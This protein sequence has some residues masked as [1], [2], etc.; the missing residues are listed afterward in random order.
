MSLNIDVATIQRFHVISGQK[1]L[2]VRSIPRLLITLMSIST[3]FLLQMPHRMFISDPE[4][5]G[6]SLRASS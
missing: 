1:D 4:E 6:S 2:S 5:K 3:I